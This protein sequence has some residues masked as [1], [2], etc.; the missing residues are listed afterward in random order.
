MKRLLLP[1]WALLLALPLVAQEAK[2][3]NRNVR[4]GLPA[5]ASTERQAYLIERPQY[6]LSYNAKTRTPNWVCWRL[7]HDDLGKAAR[8]PFVPDPDLPKNI[9]KVTTHVYDGSG[10]DRGHMCPAQDRSAR[11]S[12]MDATFYTTNIIPQS[13]NCNQRGWERL[14]AYCRELTHD[15]HVL[16]IASGPAGVGGEGKDGDKKEIGKSGL[17]VTVPAK[18]WKVILVLPDDKAEPTRATRVIAVIMP[19]TQEV[20]FDW[21]KHRVSVAEVEKLTGF[22][23]WPNLPRELAR[24]L[25]AK[26]DEVKVKTPKS[27]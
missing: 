7:S 3:T 24:D 4:F 9:A 26:V 12:D 8:G 22:N 6:V 13:P 27:K 17:E 20:D 14:E 18:V 19:N 10:F 21:A 23:F 5:A 1:V 2:E 25:K 11:Q 15:G 16:W